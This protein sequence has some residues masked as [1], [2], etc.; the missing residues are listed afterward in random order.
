MMREARVLDS[1]ADLGD[2]AVFLPHLEATETTAEDPS[3]IAGLAASGAGA[4]D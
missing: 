3:P 4:A 2:H 1:L